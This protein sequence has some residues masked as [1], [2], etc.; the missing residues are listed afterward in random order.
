LLREIEEEARAVGIELK[1][2]EETKPPSGGRA[3]W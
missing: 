3:K 1:A 2:E